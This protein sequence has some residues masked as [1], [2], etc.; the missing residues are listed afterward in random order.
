[1]GTLFTVSTFDSDVRGPLPDWRTA[2]SIITIAVCTGALLAYVFQLTI[3]TTPLWA[4]FVLLPVF[5]ITFAL[6]LRTRRSRATTQGGDSAHPRPSDIELES[7]YRNSPLGLCAFDENLKIT[8]VNETMA[9]ILGRSAEQLIGNS[10]DE[11]APE[12]AS[13]WKAPLQATL[14]GDTARHSADISGESS[15]HPGSVRV[16]ATNFHRVVDLAGVLRGINVVA[17]DV[18]DVRRAHEEH[19]AHRAILQLAASQAPLDTICE[20]LVTSLRVVFPS[21]ICY[22]IQDHQRGGE[23]IP[24]FHSKEDRIESLFYPSLPSE[25]N[26]MFARA[27]NARH[28]LLVPEIT[29][30]PPG[31]LRDRMIATGIRSCWIKPIT[32]SNGDVWGACVLNHRAI[33]LAPS[34]LEREHLDVLIRLV[35]T[36][37]ERR[38]FYEQLASTTERLE[39]AERAG[40][41]GVFDW[42]PQTGAIVWTR[43]M[44]ELFGLAPGAFHG[45]FAEWK[46]LLHPADLRRVVDTIKEVVARHEPWFKTSHRFLR[47]SGEYGWMEVQGALT[48]DSSGSPIRGVGVATD[49][50]ERTRAE[51]RS[52][53]D[54]ERLSLALEAGGLGLWDWH[55]PSDE[56]QFGGSWAAMLGYSLDEIYYTL[57]SWTQLVHPD[58]LTEARA[59]LDRHFRRESP[60]YECEY[61]L[62]KKDGTWTWVLDRGRVIEWDDAGKPVRAI[63]I[64]ADI[65]EQRAARENLKIA[66]KRKDEFLA[67]LAHELRNPLA[68]IRTGLQIIR[69]DPSSQEAARAREMMERQ[70]NHMVRLVDDLL[71]V[72]R[73]T[74]GQMDL[75]KEDVSIQDI[76]TLAIESSTPAIDTGGQVFHYEIPSAVIK[77]HGD[78]T[79]LAQIISNLLVNAAKYTPPGGDISLTARA[80]D[81]RVVIQVRDTGAGIPSEMLDCVFEMFSQVNRTL[82]RSQGGLGIGL[83]LARKI[84]EMHGGDIHVESAGVGKGSVFTV[85]LPRIIRDPEAVSASESIE[86]TREEDR[87]KRVFIIDDNIDGAASLGMYLEMLGHQ[88]SIFHSGPAAL[89]QLQQHLPDIIF[90]DIGLPGMTG[91]EVAKTIRSMPHGN[92]PLIAAV[93]GWGTEEDKRKTAAAGCSIHLTKPIDLAEVERLVA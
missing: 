16:W 6:L 11:S 87:M 79:R 92:E 14:H 7:I 59:A 72:S 61:R 22:I 91:Y 60:T 84:V 33:S 31:P 43:Q 68:P 45:T 20:V 2:A 44:E 78:P 18:T 66:A 30:E 27:I 62:R 51:N 41:I 52:R 4:P 24:F 46:K 48:Y 64:N 3:G 55:I 76:L 74:R 29:A 54:Q 12:V 26:S 65:S 69:L 36:V 90:L 19:R 47:K 81:G 70:L 67:T 71:D 53:R 10:L 32:L 56:V 28:E 88:V 86:A 23:V 73:I 82:D 25:P 39:C 63:G 83:A 80:R 77:T 17:E 49:I 50:T 5:L 75:R 40:K 35:A 93:T 58:D 85:E 57:Q 13:V 38:D 42:N 89:E 15:T 9:S 1:M 37:I 21:T 8:R 34:E